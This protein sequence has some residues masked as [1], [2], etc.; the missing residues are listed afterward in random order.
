MEEITEYRVTR[1]AGST[2][3]AAGTLLYT[4]EHEGVAW[5]FYNHIDRSAHEGG[6]FARLKSP[7]FSAD[8]AVSAIIFAAHNSSCLRSSLTPPS[9]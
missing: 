3:V 2:T 7:L 4:T 8:F 9:S 1:H 5:R 6:C